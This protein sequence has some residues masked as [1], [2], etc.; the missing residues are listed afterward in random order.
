M[1]WFHAPILAMDAGIVKPST[2]TLFDASVVYNGTFIRQ[3][4][5]YVSAALRINGFQ[6][7]PGAPV[8]SEG[9]A[10]NAA[11]NAATLPIA[12]GS[13]VSLYGAGIA[14]T[15][16]EASSLPL[17]ATLANVTV[18]V[19]GF[20]APLLFVSPGQINLQIPWEL[21]IGNGT[22]PIAVI[23]SGGP[24]VGTR[25]GS[26]VNG[27]PSNIISARVANA[28]PGV[29]AIVQSS[30]GSLT[31]TNPAG[32]DDVLIVYANGLGPVDSPVTTGG[33]PSVL[34][35]TIETP[36]VTIG[37][38]PAEVL[39]S[40]LAPGFAGLYQMNLKVPA[41]VRAGSTI[42]LVVSTGGQTSPPY[43]IATR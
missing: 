37:G 26:P 18:Y 2:N 23:V 17:P 43:F 3:R 11:P 13:L 12:P 34:T 14:A 1:G 42:P 39:F 20:P 5:P 7:P 4:Y 25:T 28:S 40:G 30:D 31:T 33:P 24:Y 19:N 10:V 15:I 21:G 38:V 9:G 35:R 32:V 41:G 27:T 22:A 29:F 16:A 6:P 8:L 36:F